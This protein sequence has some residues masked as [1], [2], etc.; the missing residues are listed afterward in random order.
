MPIIDARLNNTLAHQFADN[1]TVTARDLP[2]ASVEIDDQISNAGTH[3]SLKRENDSLVLELFKAR[4]DEL[5]Q[6]R[7]APYVASIFRQRLQDPEFSNLPAKIALV[8]SLPKDCFVDRLKLPQGELRGEKLKSDSRVFELVAQTLNG[9]GK[10]S[11][12]IKRQ[13]GNLIDAPPGG[14]C[15]I[16]TR[17][18]LMI[19]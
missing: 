7:R 18:E 2:Y 3:R 9:I 10:D 15:G 16:R 4:G 11:R 19:R 8:E 17:L 1:S 6:L 13:F 12:V 14:L 5:E